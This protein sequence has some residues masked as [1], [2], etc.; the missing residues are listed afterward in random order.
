MVKSVLASFGGID[1]HVVFLGSFLG[2]GVG[3]GVSGGIVGVSVHVDTLFLSLLSI[4]WFYF[5]SIFYPRKIENENGK[6]E[7]EI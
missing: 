7:K 1:A 5:I 4:L 6:I 3:V 2:L